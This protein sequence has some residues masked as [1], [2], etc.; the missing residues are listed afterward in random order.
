MQVWRCEEAL[1]PGGLI[2]SPASSPEL[3]CLFLEP[4]QSKMVSLGRTSVNK[5]GKKK[6]AVIN[7]LF[8]FFL[9]LPSCQHPSAAPKK[10]KIELEATEK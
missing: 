3:S 7:A 8:F 9:S 1:S 2:Y 6:K 10:G 5:R 4:H